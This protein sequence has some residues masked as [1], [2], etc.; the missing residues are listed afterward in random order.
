MENPWLTIAN[1]NAKLSRKTN[2][3]L[4]SK[5]S[6]ADVRSQAVLKKQLAR[7]EEALAHQAEDALVEIDPEDSLPLPPSSVSFQ[8]TNGKKRKSSQNIE[9]AAVDSAF[10]DS[11]DEGVNQGEQSTKAFKQRELVALAFA[12]DN[13]I[14]VSTHLSACN[15]AYIILAGIQLQQT[16]GDRGGGPKRNRHHIA[17]LGAHYF[18]GKSASK[19]SH[20]LNRVFGAERVSGSVAAS[21]SRT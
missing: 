3:A 6:S 19:Q 8:T 2:E 14:E 9:S 21:S 16:E 17:W 10:Q 11:D 18:T 5:G 20:A 12:G 15:F 13:V 4:V 7:S 1:T